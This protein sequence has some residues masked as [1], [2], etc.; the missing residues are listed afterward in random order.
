M[1]EPTPTPAPTPS[2]EEGLVAIMEKSAQR[3]EEQML[4]KFSK[5]LDAAAATPAPSAPV[6]EVVE[7]A[8]GRTERIPGSGIRVTDAS[9]PLYRCFEGTGLEKYRTPEA[10]HWCQRWI[11]GLIKH[12]RVAV[13]TAYE[14]ANRS[15]GVRAS[16]L[17]G[18]PGADGAIGTATGADLLPVPLS[19]AVEIARDKVSKIPQRATQIELTSQTTRI[20]T[21][22]AVAA[23]MVDEATA[24]TQTEPAF[25]HV[26]PRANKM[27]AFMKASVETIAD[28]AFNLLNI[29]AAR[30]GAAMGALEDV[31]ICTTN[32]TAPNFTTAWTGTDVTEA[33]STVLAFGDVAALYHAV[34]QQYRTNAA[35]FGATLVMQLLTA[36]RSVS[37]SS[38]TQM[39]YALSERPGTLADDPQSNGS[40]FGKPVFEVPLAAGVL[41]FGDPT[42][43]GMCRR[44]GITAS[45]SEHADFASDLIQFKFISRV[46]GVVIDATANA[47]SQ[48]AGLLTVA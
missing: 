8:A 44:A 39:L 4:A 45:V 24:L 22:G 1:S 11:Q 47:T 27:Q 9:E 36:M 41:L 6:R 19:R 37:T 40:I 30:A 10:D 34:P 14:K 7:V 3:A 26:I 17:E 43:Y 5:M 12:D 38:G 21:V 20:T 16:S 28:S 25:E 18:D 32:G 31:Q 2:V 13:L 23:Q 33:A 35:F 15:V 29:Y 42:N 48:I 46:D